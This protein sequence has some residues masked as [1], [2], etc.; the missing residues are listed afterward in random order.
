MDKPEE[1]PL[2]D[3][4]EPKASRLTTIVLI[5]SL[6]LVVLVAGVLGTVAVLMTRSPDTPLLGGTPPQRLAVPI[7][8]APVR[9]TKVAPCPGDPAVLDEKQTTCYLLEDGVTVGAVQRIEAVRGNDGQYSVRIAIAPAFKDRLVELI[10]E[11]VPDQRA[12]AIVLAPEQADKPKVVL[13]APIVTQQMNGDSVSIS[14]LTEQDADALVTR[15]MGGT[16]SASPTGTAGTPDQGSPNQGTPDQGTPDQGT[17]GTGSPQQ[18]TGPATTGPAGTGQPG[19]GDAATPPANGGRAPDKRYASCKEAVA[20]GDGPYYRG[21]HE[22]YTWYVD[23]DAN[24]VA[25]NS[26]DIR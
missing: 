18:P 10:D 5:V 12:V 25:C 3:P 20:A 22:E 7:H 23:V 9:E 11:L 21:T 24:G 14:G 17:P 8:F 2:A 16:P 4:G 19:G 1:P 15:L 13:A 6:V 26:A